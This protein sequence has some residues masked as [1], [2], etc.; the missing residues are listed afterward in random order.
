MDMHVK[1]MPTFLAQA[2]LHAVQHGIVDLVR[3]CKQCMQMHGVVTL[4]YQRSAAQLDPES[5][6]DRLR[7]VSKSWKDLGGKCYLA[8]TPLGSLWRWMS[9]IRQVTSYCLRN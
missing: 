1:D 9:A 4:F 7:T 2:N 8:C 6:L 3:W 5:C